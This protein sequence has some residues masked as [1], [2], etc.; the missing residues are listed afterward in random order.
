MKE[1]NITRTTYKVSDF[2]NWKRNNLLNISPSFQRRSVW[3]TSQ[4]S[5]LIDSISKGLPIP[6]IFLRESTDLSTFEPKREVVD[7]QQ[8]IRTVISFIAPN[9]LEDYRGDKDYFT[10][11]KIHNEDLSSRDFKDLD[12]KVQE[13]ILNYEFGVHVLPPSMDDKEI[14]KIFARMNATGVRLNAQELRNAEFFGEFKEAMYDLAYEQL[15]RWRDWDLFSENQ[16]AR[17]S[18]VEFTSDIALLMF[19][20]ISTKSPVSLNKLYKSK[21]SS[22]PESSVVVNRFQT[23]MNS[24][25]DSIGSIIK[26]SVFSRKTMFYSLFAVFYD[27]HYKLNSSLKKTTKKPL[28]KNIKGKLIEI[29]SKF[30]KGQ[31]PNDI[32][33]CITTRTSTIQT[34]KPLFKYLL[35]HVNK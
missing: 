20:G 26:G 12:K 14:L 17:M 6:V 30:K 11:K 10:V 22:F 7:G 13:K 29:N 16:I 28:P 5:L 25:D 35:N 24:I 21:D 8:R 9:I 3:N 31:I 2:I 32:A 4:K 27:Y 15:S 19:N 1:W 33:L 18:E 23:V 34:R